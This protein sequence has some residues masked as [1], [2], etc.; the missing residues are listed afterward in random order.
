MLKRLKYVGCH[1][2]ESFQIWIKFVHEIVV[3][4]AGNFQLIVLLYFDKMTLCVITAPGKCTCG[5]V[6]KLYTYIIL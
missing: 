2:I 6:V 1:D 4:R 5:M 3:G